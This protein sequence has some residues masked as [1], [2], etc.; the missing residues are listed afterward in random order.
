M[1]FALHLSSMTEY[2]RVIEDLFRRVPAFQNVGKVA[3]KKDLSNISKIME[4]FD[5][6]HLQYPTIHIA[7]TNGKGTC[8]HLIASVLQ[9]SGFKVGIYT[10]PHY[11]DFRERIKVN[12]QLIGQSQ[13]LEFIKTVDRTITTVKPSFF[14]ISVAMAFDH[15]K[16]QKV[17]IAVI[18]TG[19]GGRLDSTNIV[20]P[21][22]SLITNIGLDHQN[23][24]GHTI[25]EIAHS[26]AGII[27]QKTPVVIGKYQSS[28]DAVFLKQSREKKAPIS[29]ANLKWTFQRTEETTV[30]EKID[31]H[32]KVT[33]NHLEDSPFIPENIVSTLEVFSQLK[34]SKILTIDDSD[35]TLGIQNFRNNTNYKGRWQILLNEPLTIADSAHNLAALRPTIDTIQKTGKKIHF[36]LG[37]VK[38][39]EIDKIL[40]LFEE[41]HT[42]HFTQPEIFRAM[43]LDELKVVSQH[44]KAKKYYLD[45]VPQAIEHAR[46]LCSSNEII[47]ISGSSFVVGEAIA[48]LEK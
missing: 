15:F 38:G 27:K 17:D 30:F 34:G 5:N 45:T 26:K 24:L 10:S 11:V 23:I 6:P 42:F 22:I 2:Q 48:H 43:P 29:F 47:F 9:Q 32:R 1:F 12:G 40:H 44:F 41:G 25:Y 20:E 3:Y 28:C 36:I 46:S 39:K 8:A 21:I 13:V 4:Q 14:E 33:I 16:K 7:G 35:I 19:L 37:F 31:G 18:E